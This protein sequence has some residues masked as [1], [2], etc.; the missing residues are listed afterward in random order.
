MHE[1][2]QLP[3]VDLGDVYGA[4]DG[5]IRSAL[6]RAAVVEAL[7]E[8]RKRDKGYP[9]LP[10][11]LSA[12]ARFIWLPLVLTICVS[13]TAQMVL[14]ER[15]RISAVAHLIVIVFVG[16]VG[17]LSLRSG[18]WSYREVYVA[19]YYAKLDALT[20]SSLLRFATFGSPQERIVP[21][22]VRVQDARRW[23]RWLT[24]AALALVILLAFA[25]CTTILDCLWDI[26]LITTVRPMTAY[27]VSASIYGQVLWTLADSI[28]V[29][30][31][32]SAFQWADPAPFHNSALVDIT[33]LVVRVA[34]FGPVI[35]WIISAYKGASGDPR[36]PVASD[37][38]VSRVIRGLNTWKTFTSPGELLPEDR[39]VVQ[40]LLSDRRIAGRRA[41]DLLDDR[42][43]Y[44]INFTSK[45]LETELAGEWPPDEVLAYL[46]ANSHAFG[47]PPA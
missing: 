17:W 39:Q 5:R 33:L 43:F 46:V 12:V 27:A 20:R 22:W 2:L 47:S 38:V 28:P 40:Q 23:A 44:A 24:L 3:Q 36:Q 45:A 15:G 31:L 11:R 9:W 8:E 7:R 30:D 4:L 1:E 13:P 25:L 34:V 18:A 35:A 19:A 14:A 10:F 26:K 32:P 16:V 42:W 41:G 37:E 6:N 21:A 29:L